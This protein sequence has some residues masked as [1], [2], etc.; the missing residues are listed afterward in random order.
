MKRRQPIPDGLHFGNPTYQRA[1]GGKVDDYRFVDTDEPLWPDAYFTR[2]C[3]A[4]GLKPTP[5]GH[6]P[7]L[8]TLPGVQYACCGHG[9]ERGYIM[10]ENGT[11]V[12]GPFEAVERG[13]GTVT[14]REPPCRP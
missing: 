10:F 14:I 1:S 4:C 5:E 2:E 11:I 7:C 13:A 12:R 3:P 9:L 8:G 6:D